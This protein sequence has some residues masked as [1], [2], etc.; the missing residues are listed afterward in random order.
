M[1]LRNIEY[2]SIKRS[3]VRTIALSA[4]LKYYDYPKML[5]YLN[6]DLSQLLNLPLLQLLSVGTWSSGTGAS[7]TCDA[8]AVCGQLSSSAVAAAAAAAMTQHLCCSLWP[9]HSYS[10]FLHFHCLSLLLL[11]M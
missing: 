2:R 9:S 7:S 4:I 11:L 5:S 10:E 6:E 1:L 8:G 3:I